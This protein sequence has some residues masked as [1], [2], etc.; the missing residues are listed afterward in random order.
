MVA[1]LTDALPVVH[2]VA[3][4]DIAGIHDSPLVGGAFFPDILMDDLLRL[5]VS[6]VISLQ[7]RVS[8]LEL[9]E[10]LGVSVVNRVCQDKNI[11]DPNL[12]RNELT[13]AFSKVKKPRFQLYN[14]TNLKSETGNTTR[15][16]R[17]HVI[18]NFIVPAK[19]IIRHGGIVLSDPV[20]QRAVVLREEKSPPITTYDY[21]GGQ[22]EEVRLHFSPEELREGFALGVHA[23]I[24]EPGEDP[25]E[26]IFETER[27]AYQILGFYPDIYV[28]EAGLYQ[29]KH[30]R[31][32]ER[33]TADEVLRLRKM[34]IYSF[35][36]ICSFDFWIA[37]TL[38]QID[39][40]ERD[41]YKK[42]WHIQEFEKDSWRKEDRL[43]EMYLAV[44]SEVQKAA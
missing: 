32:S 11:Y 44:A 9:T 40:A 5:G 13:R 31:F 7:P 24:F 6:S 4:A 43:A 33:V 17:Q 8:V 23:Y 12:M 19:E 16:P 10:S 1:A 37:H 36:R 22:L 30:R 18:D 21:L 28:T 29:D 25:R 15:R 3:I 41:A 20:A 42:L 38:A 35:S 14:E 34:K 27:I 26:H 39:P 2:E